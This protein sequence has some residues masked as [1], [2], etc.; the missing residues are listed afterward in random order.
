M[1]AWDLRNLL[2]QGSVAKE[3]RTQQGA[4]ISLFLKGLSTRNISIGA[5]GRRT[6]R[7]EGSGKRRND[8]SER[9]GQNLLFGGGA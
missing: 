2:G 7:R 6:S 1:P 9:S 3:K 5:G 8:R 4:W